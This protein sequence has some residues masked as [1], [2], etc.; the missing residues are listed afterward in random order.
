MGWR[1]WLAAALMGVSSLAAAQV[2]L[3]RP[4]WLIDVPGGPAA[5]LQAALWYPT[6]AVATVMRV[7]PLEMAVAP[8]APVTPGRHPLVLVSHGAAGSEYAHAWLAEGLAVRGYLVAALR[9]PHDNTDD[10]SLLGT[11]AFFSE[12]PKD[13]SRLLDAL[14]ADPAWAPLIDA[15]RIAVVGHSAG[16]YTA[17]ALAGARPDLAR[18]AAHCAPDGPGPLDDAVFCSLNERPPRAQPGAA[19]DLGA[20]ADPRIR[21]AAVAAPLA[22]VFDPASL[23]SL[24][25]PLLV[26]NSGHDGLL[27]PAFHGGAVCAADAAARCTTTASAGHRAFVQAGLAQADGAPDFDRAGYQREALARIEA[28]LA[29]SLR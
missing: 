11:A 12:R 27:A 10:R 23:A 8:G 25:V 6:S 5:R 18:L 28:F 22:V 24:R 13:V 4:S 26:E 20:L 2:G 15:R 19:A 9:Q 16:G 14:L 21:A 17:L 3:Q 1:A 7:G 29:D